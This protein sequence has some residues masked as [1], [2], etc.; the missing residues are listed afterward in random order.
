MT[1]STMAPQRRSLEPLPFVAPRAPDRLLRAA[2]TGTAGAR[3]SASLAV[4]ERGLSGRLA[5]ARIYDDVTPPAV[6]DSPEDIDR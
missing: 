1:S 6:S 3:R 5:A 2:E 4:Y